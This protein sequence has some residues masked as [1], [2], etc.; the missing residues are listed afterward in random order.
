[1]VNNGLIILV[2]EQLP[3]L[4]L[5]PGS[6]LNQG[7]IRPFLTHKPVNNVSGVFAVS[8]NTILQQVMLLG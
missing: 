7:S 6:K 8:E 5:R 1:M 2:R 4:A 3:I